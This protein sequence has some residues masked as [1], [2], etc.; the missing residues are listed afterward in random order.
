MRALCAIAFLSCLL[1]ASLV[2]AQP[3]FPALTGRVVDT[4]NILDASTVASI[5]AQLQAHESDTSNQ[6]VVATVPS[7]QGYDIADF[8][9]Q[10]A[11]HWQIGTAENDNGVVLLVAPNERKVRI[12]VGYGL[13]GAL[14]DALAGDI[15]RKRILPSFREDQ[16]AVGVKNGVDSIIQAI[17][18]EYQIDTTEGGRSARDR[19][20]VLA[21][22]G[23]FAIVAVSMFGRKRFN[24]NVPSRAIV[25]AGFFGLMSFAATNNPFV[26]VTVLLAA[27]GIS[28]L[29]LKQRDK[30]R[31]AR[32]VANRDRHRRGWAHE[33]KQRPWHD[34]NRSG[35]S[36]GGFSGGGGGFG[37]GGASGGW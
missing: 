11:S 33:D 37:G 26:A 25:P 13:E 2:G 34:R 24:D 7:L 28:I 5:E 3:A 14:P 31:E 30:T 10:L 4:A 18:G 23:F 17:E 35:S 27:F 19:L 32:R 21:P 36:G 20:G 1:Q 15:I 22:I 29:V 9:V 16:Y 6:I 8:G 12:D